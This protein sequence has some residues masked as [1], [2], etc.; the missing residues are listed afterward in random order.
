MAQFGNTNQVL[1]TVGKLFYIE[2]WTTLAN[3]AAV[4]RLWYKV[5]SFTGAGVTYGE[6]LSQMSS[7]FSLAFRNCVGTGAN[8][9]GF[10]IRELPVMGIPLPAPAYDNTAALPGTITGNMLPHQ[11]AG[12]LSLRTAFAGRSGRGRLYMPFPTTSCSGLNGTILP[13]YSTPLGVFAALVPATVTVTGAGGNAV[14]T[15][16]LVNR[17][18]AVWKV[19]NN[20]LVSSNFATQRRRGDYGRPNVSPV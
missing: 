19:I 14:L 20:V 9:K 2:Y 5:T 1:N 17:K 10:G 15:P 4:N 18:T 6:V 16:V 11:V 3:Q 12:L 7:I 13:A 8:F